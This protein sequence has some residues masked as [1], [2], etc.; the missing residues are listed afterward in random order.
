VRPA[1]LALLLFASASSA[2][3]GA[4]APEPNFQ[5]VVVKRGDTLWG[6]A[7]AYLKDPSKWD[8]ILRHNKLPSNDPTVAL[9]G[10]TLKVPIQ[11]I[12]ENMRAAHLIY[13]IN[14]V[15]FRR[16]E[17]ADWKPAESNMELFRGDTIRTLD[18]AK[19]KVRFL[20]ADLLSIE[21]NSMAVIK[22]VSADYD[23]ELKSGGVFVGHSRVVTA[24]AKITPKTQDTQYSAKVKP[25]LSTLV[26]VYTGV[27]AVEG[28]GK[29]VD[30]RAGMSSEVKLGLAP[31]APKKIADLPDFEARAADFNGEQIRGQARVK[32]AVGAQLAY[33]AD[34]DAINKAADAGELKGDV[35]SLSVG[36]PIS[37]YRVQASRARDFEKV[38]FNKIFEPE[39]RVELDRQNLPPGVYWFRI[40]LIDLLGTEEKYSSPRLYSVGLGD[41]A[42][43]NVDLKS[44]F[45]LSKPTRDE[46]VWSDTYKVQGLVKHDNLTVTVNG[47]TVRQDENGNF[48]LDVKLRQGVNDVT[49]TVSNAGGDSTSVT[50]RLTY[51]T[52]Y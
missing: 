38:I 19:A 31:G 48:F 3:A 15:I 49:V 12:K 25:D 34:A 46:D 8:Q 36:V 51:N 37:G 4:E 10:M 45:V 2:G 39:E 43:G 6:I 11:L 52:R 1:L 42:S 50:R 29:S 20:N 47:R 35:A 27:A 23:V 21:A 16:K 41:R 18:S 17:T 26:E 30:V 7:N 24:S 28:A 33:G 40:A 14:R 13:M 44:S 9:P 22:P 5:N 32:V